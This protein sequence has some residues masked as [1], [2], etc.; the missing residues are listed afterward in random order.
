M[1]NGA[2]SYRRFL[3]GDD[4]GL[5]EIIR[6][7]K[8]GLIFYLNGYVKNIHTAEDLAED[9]FFKLAVKRPRFTENHSFKTWL[10]TIGRNAAINHLKKASKIADKPISDYTEVLADERSLEEDYIKSEEKIIL[11]RA[12]G[13][14]NPDYA[15]VLHLVYFEEMNNA[16]AAKVLKKN[17]RQIENLLY[18][19]KNALKSE[20]EKEGFTYEKLRRDGTKRS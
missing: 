9:T 11:H 16:D 14:L 10:Y 1:D 17:K 19:A 2:S 20:L 7:Y 12:I 5:V 6:D 3:N 18:R 8:D 15:G 4:N 13:K